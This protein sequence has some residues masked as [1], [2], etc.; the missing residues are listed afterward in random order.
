MRS[1]SRISG[2][3]LFLFLLV[4]TNPVRAQQQ[5]FPNTEHE[6][7]ILT[8][9]VRNGLGNYVMGVRPEAFELTDEKDR[10]PIEFFE[11][12]DTP[13]SI[14]ILID[15]SSSMQ[16]YENREIARPVPIAEALSRFLELSNTGNEYFLMTF[17]R[18]PH[19]LTDWTSGQ[20][21]LAHKT[22]IVQQNN[23]TALY[24][25]C[26]AAIEK[27]QTAHHP[28]RVL[29]LISDGQDNLSRHTF[30]QLRELLKDSEV[31]IYGIGVVMPSDVGSSLGA[32]GS[33][34][35]MELAE[36]T[37][38]ETFPSRTRKELKQAI[39]SITIQLRHQYRIGFRADKTGPAHKWH[40]LK[41]RVNSSPNAPK[42]FSKL[43]VRTRPGYYSR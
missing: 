38:G 28:K 2:A 31:M 42:E 13:V 4:L 23:D 41:L 10:R 18:A 9:T 33:G 25:S 34:I 37:G 27:L 22:D 12:L 26:F 20:S 43:T 32:E 16:L 39:E 6:L 3:I 35:M 40:R 30:N 21:L 15:T 1:S 19:L 17:D 5:A 29:M 7:R 8:I 11:N 14:G 36:I 24:D